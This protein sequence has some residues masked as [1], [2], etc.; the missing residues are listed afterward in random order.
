MNTGLDPFVDT[1]G[2][3]SYFVTPALRQRIDLVRHLIEFGRQIV[4][5]TGPPGAGKSVLIENVVDTH[6][7][8]WRVVR[9]NAGPTLNHATLLG[10]TAGELGLELPAGDDAVLTDAIRKRVKAANQRGETT[11]LAIDDAHTLPS[12]T[13]AYLAKLAHSVDESAELKVVLSADPARSPLIDQLQSESYQQALVHVVE[14]PRLNEEQTRDMLTHR[15]HAAYGNDEIP[16]DQDTMSRIHRQST[17]IPGKAIVLARQVQR[18]ADSREVRSRDPA[19]A[20]V[21]GGVAMLVAFLLFAFFNTGDRDGPRDKA[22][23]RLE[24]P[25]ETTVETGSA[26]T[27]QTR[28]VE[29]EPATH[30]LVARDHGDRLEAVTDEGRPVAAAPPPEPP[31]PVPAQT[32]AGQRGPS[33]QTPILTESASPAP[34]ERKPLAPG[35]TADKP[36][37]PAPT[38]SAAPPSVPTAGSAPTPTEKAAP[39][40]ARKFPSERYSIEWLRAQAAGGYVLQLFGVRDRKA[41]VDYIET[42]KIGGK[43]TVLVTDHQGAP[44]YVVVYGHYP[45]RMAAKAAIVDLPAKLA[46]TKPW[47]RPVASLH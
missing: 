28:H 21:I 13:L 33:E 15:W 41:A 4:V 3:K 10:R 47:A 22:R 39:P 19:K 17:G 18:R 29:S 37:L 45:D 7:R 14:I 1:K 24:L 2:G 11:V 5:L 34:T 27:A 46:A 6:E 12:D 38:A 26:T 8:S 43:S 16:L 9:F 20:Y 31:I 23:I 25:V 32:P 40:T 30:E 42:R 35:R 44:W 36:Q